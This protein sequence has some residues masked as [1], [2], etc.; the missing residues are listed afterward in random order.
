MIKT[1]ILSG[2]GIEGASIIGC[3]DFLY[4]NDLL[5]NIETIWGTSIGSLFAICICL[6]YNISIIK[7]ILFNFDFT[8]LYNIND[9]NIIN[10]FNN[11][12]V[13]DGKN[14]EIFVSNIIKYK[15]GRDNITLK[16]L[17]DMSKITL[18]INC[19]CLNTIKTQIFSWKTH[20]DLMVKDICLIS[21]KIPFFYYGK[22]ID[23]LYYCDGFIINNWCIN[24]IDNIEEVLGIMIINNIDK[25]EINNFQ[26][27]SIQILKCLYHRNQINILDKYKDFIVEINNSKYIDNPLD[28]NLTKN[29][30]NR[31]YNLGYNKMKK[32]Y[33]KYKTRF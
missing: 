33:K 2:G 11:Y 31:M 10:I 18:N 7:N 9:N 22:K 17:Y 14:M 24:L 4:K 16:E 21:M 6:N 23:N 5:K 25:S 32:Y 30:K 29:I 12:G 1:L 27:Y 3:L 8:L 26:D 19:T 20:P 15:I 13:D 28:F